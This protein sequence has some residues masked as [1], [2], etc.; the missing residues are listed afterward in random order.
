LFFKFFCTIF[1]ITLCL[2]AF[3][4]N[5]PIKSFE[6][7]KN[8]E[9]LINGKSFFPIM[10]F[11]QD[12]T[13][14]KDAVS[15]GINTFFGN[16]SKLSDR[17]YIEKLK[18][19]GAYGILKFS[20]QLIS[21][22]NLFG[23]YIE[24]EP[25]KRIPVYEVSVEPG[26]GLRVNPKT[27]FSRILDGNV[28]SW[29]VL[30]PLQN[31]EVIINLTKEV[32][33]Y[34]VGIAITVASTLSSPKV[35]SFIA[36][37]DTEILRATLQEKRGI[38]QK[39]QLPQPVKLSTLICKVVDIYKHEE[40]YGSIGEIEAYDKNGNNILRN[41]PVLQKVSVEEWTKR[42]NEIK[43]KDRTKPVI[44]KLTSNFME[45]LPIMGWN[46]ET[47][48][49]IYPE[50]IKNSDIVGFGVY[51]VYE[52][53]NYDFLTYVPKGTETLCKL[54][55][56][57]P[58]F[59]WIETTKGN[60]NIEPQTQKEVLPYHTRAEVWMAII[61]GAK[62]IGYYTHSSWIPNIKE[63]P[64]ISQLLCT[65]S[66]GNNPFALSEEMKIELKKL[67][68]Q[69]K[70]LSSAILSP[71]YQGNIEMKNEHGLNCHFKATLY[72]DRI[73][74]FAQNLELI[75]GGKFEIKIEGIKDGEVEVIDE[76][77]TIKIKDGKF[78]D[79]FPPLKEHIYSIKIN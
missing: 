45:G 28:F 27:P 71:P 40:T 44:L 11:N 50:Y 6:I 62:G 22:P 61:K 30:D 3:S 41:P 42:Y 14:I 24:D 10:I 17:E 34:G 43:Q 74:I 79:H 4:E 8:N 46:E 12:E 53:N 69:I 38:V 5:E 16:G 64:G 70:R 52:L 75:K 29:T 19:N 68:E 54:T 18:E 56:N 76:N 73:F 39:F 65:W 67:N 23:W 33:I 63:V 48:K 49:K 78:I 60:R 51:P 7:G 2:Y 36:D 72:N 21:H 55:E 57:K 9:I 13:K 32:E 15:I 20:S 35:V 47:K 26:K 1:L 58:V 31:A 25:D 77:R 37:D 59:V 66:V